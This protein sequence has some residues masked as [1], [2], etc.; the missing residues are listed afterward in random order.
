KNLVMA[1]GVALNCVGN[2]KILRDGC[3][4]N[5]WVQ[6]AAGDAGGALGAAVF[7]LHQLL[8]KPRD[9]DG[10]YDQQRGSL[11]GPNFE[12]D[13]L[14]AFFEQQ[15]AKYH[16]YS[17]E[18]ALVDVVS[19][20][21]VNQKVVGH[22]AGRMEFGPRALGNRSILGDP[23]SPEMQRTM[24]LKIKFRESFR[25]FA[26]S[27][28]RDAVDE[29]F[30]MRPQEESPYM[31]LVAPVCESKRLAEGNTADKKG[32]ELLNVVRSK[33]PAVTHVDF[34]ARVQTVD[35]QRNPRY[36]RL[37]K[38]FEQKT[39]CPLVIN[40]SFNIRGEPI[41]CTPADAYHCFLGCNMDVLVV[42]KFVLYKDEQPES[43]VDVEQYKDR[44]E[45]D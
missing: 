25:P 9:V 17:D 37:I 19:E 40:T 38:R 15:G 24:N 12:G 43:H 18:D 41:V 42:D 3:F 36:Y 44:F 6:P 11:L 23:R 5:I 29:W 20:A 4:D 34:S 14:R 2:G 39:G 35:E 31:L 26:P 30:E 16:Y 22:M 10:V 13:G 7:F 1:G 28:L 21:L 8:G 33:V 27:V 45:L 32:I